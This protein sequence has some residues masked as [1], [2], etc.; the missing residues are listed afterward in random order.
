MEKK[1]LLIRRPF[2]RKPTCVC[3]QS[4]AY[5]A[6]KYTGESSAQAEFNEKSNEKRKNKTAMT[7]V[8]MSE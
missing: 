6:Q 5:G 1:V 2:E 8:L 4:E 7:Y 3:I